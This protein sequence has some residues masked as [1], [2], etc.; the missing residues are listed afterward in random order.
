[1]LRVLCC[2]VF[3]VFNLA[4]F[5]GE[6]SKE[7]RDFYYTAHIDVKIDKGLFDQLA[8]VISESEIS[9]EIKKLRTFSQQDKS[10]SSMRALR[11][12][13]RQDVDT[14]Y[15]TAY[16][17]GFYNAQVK[18]D[19]KKQDGVHVDVFVD[20][21]E[22]FN[23]KLNLTFENQDE[24]FHN[25]YDP[26]FHQ[27]LRTCK[28]SMRDMERL[29][30]SIV[31][32]L[33][34]NGYVKPEVIQKK[35]TVRYEEHAVELNVVV[36]TG[37]KAIF[38]HTDIKAFPGISTEFIKNRID[39]DEGDTFDIEKAQSTEEALKDTQIFSRVKVHTGE[40][41]NG[42]V[43]M[44]IKLAE[45][46]KHTVG[47][48]LLYSGMRNMNFK[49]KSQTQKQLKSIIARLSWERNN[50]FGNGEKI[51]VIAEG[52]PMKMQEKRAD[53][54]FETK[55]TQPDV[56]KKNSSMVYSVS[57]RQELTNA[58]FK[59]SDKG[60]VT[61]KYPFSKLFSASIGVSS[62]QNTLDSCDVFFY[63]SEDNRR[64]KMFAVPLEL[65][66]D[67]TD[68]LLNPTEGYRISAKL[69]KAFLRG[70]SIKDLS[71][72][73][74]GAAYTKAFD[75]LKRTIFAVNVK[76]SKIFKHAVDD[77]PIDKR[78]YA[79]GMNS[80]RGYA[81]QMACEIV[82]GEEAPFGGRRSFEY[83]TEIRRRFG[84]DFGG[85]L[86]FDGARIFENRPR[87]NNIRL[88]KKRWFCS[89]GFG[90][91]YFTS[92]GPIRLDFA[93]PI[94]RRKGIDSKMQFIMSLGQAF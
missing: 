26:I 71:I 53:Y 64:Y 5:A 13:V 84:Q 44:T 48:S 9:D 93:F 58:F 18:H 8:S 21:G 59:K 11:D 66:L 81:N 56:F 43:P 62:E 72:M 60:I 39:W 87:N 80:V 15:K 24:N 69:T 83:N 91:R 45:E 27:K 68:D 46:K 85:V 67:K 3:L 16:Y 29:I 75:D 17:H 31:F 1:M 6:N 94:K 51:N 92:I 37:E 22:V 28:A 82:E 41:E 49:K 20:L 34:K 52:T 4:S 36:N 73:E 63:N 88:E 55:L 12:R 14:M 33:Q 57:R 38:G 70:A 2:V 30:Q 23:L 47:I 32:E 7:L 19:I 78:I 74:L 65:I 86:F 61:Y 76:C 79:G 35:A 54:G 50:A 42:S 10:V 40:V 90:I 77:I 25:F 89:F